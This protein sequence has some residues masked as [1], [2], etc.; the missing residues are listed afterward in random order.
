[1][2]LRRDG[3]ER[4]WLDLDA[5][6]LSGFTII[7]TVE[8][9][10]TV[11]WSNSSHL[12]LKSS[13]YPM[14]IPV[15]LP[16]GRA[17]LA[18]S[19]ERTGSPIAMATIGI[20]LV[21]FLAAIAPGVLPVTITSTLR[22][23]TSAISAGSRSRWPSAQRRSMMRFWPSTQPSSRRRSQNALTARR[24]GGRRFQADEAQP[25]D[26]LRGVRST[27]ESRAER[28]RSQT[29]EATSEDEQNTAP[30]HRITSFGLQQNRLRDGQPEGLGGLEVDD[31]H[32]LGRLLDGQVGWL[33]ALE[34]LV[35]I[36]RCVPEHH[37]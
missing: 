4:L 12:P 13:P 37:S 16:P 3:L 10:G 27:R 36:V 20:V 33:G 23:I 34:D 25:H 17:K 32:V 6:E 29:S 11:S 7:A 1:M 18:T 21:A 5:T 24:G 35:D 15:R 2:P 19:P 30:V 31:E 14:D 8:S 9:R 28:A 22:P 26:P